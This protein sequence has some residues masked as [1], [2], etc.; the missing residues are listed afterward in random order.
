MKS[1][2]KSV[3]IIA[4]VPFWARS[5]LLLST[6]ASGLK[7]TEQFFCFVF[8]C[9]ILHIKNLSLDGA[10]SKLDLKYI[11]FAV[12]MGS[13]IF[14]SSLLG[15]FM[16]EWRGTG[17]KTKGCLALGIFVLLA[18]FCVIS[19]GGKVKDAEKKESEK[20]PAA[21]AAAAVQQQAAAQQATK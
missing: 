17:A 1:C 10:V 4:P 2:R 9:G 3:R 18:S 5:L 15:L 11:A 16:G 14:F 13:A 20:A 7:V 8:F 21:E 19:W 12:V 6:T